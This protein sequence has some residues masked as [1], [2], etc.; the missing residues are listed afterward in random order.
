MHGY[1]HEDLS[2]E[3]LAALRGLYE[4]FTD[5]VRNLVDATL[6]TTVDAAEIKVAQAAIEAITERLRADQLPGSYGVRY[7][8]DGT[9]RPWGNAVVGL[10]NPIAPPLSFRRDPEGRADCDFHLGAA[11]EGPPGLVHGGV[12]ALI[13]DQALGEACGAGRRPGMTG[14]LT[15][16]FLRPTRL[17]DLRC[18][19]WIDRTEGYKTFAKGTIGDA[20][21]PTVEAEG[22]FIVPK[23]AR[24]LFDSAQDQ[25]AQPDR[26]E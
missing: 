5:S 18:E 4:P 26:F 23:W 19:G 10:R 12:S 21:G 24:A 13:L 1:Q 22:V 20:E 7:S 15:I 11:Y 25:Q 2:D 3:Q 6:R 17:G 16:R 8:S 14:G 9:T